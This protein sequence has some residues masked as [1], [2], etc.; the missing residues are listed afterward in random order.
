MIRTPNWRQRAR[1]GFRFTADILFKQPI[2]WIP[3]AIT[4][5]LFLLAISLRL[6]LSIDGSGLFLAFGEVSYYLALAV[7][8]CFLA[9]SLFFVLVPKACEE[10]GDLSQRARADGT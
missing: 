10:Y 1:S 8:G 6:M 7:G 9:G 3:L 2:F 5:G 4:I